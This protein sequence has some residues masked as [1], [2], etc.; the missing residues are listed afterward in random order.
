MCIKCSVQPA[1]NNILLILIL[2]LHSLL[3]QI[4]NQCQ[5]T[6]DGIFLHL[7]TSTLRAPALAWSHHQ[8]TSFRTWAGTLSWYYCVT[9]NIFVCIK[10]TIFCVI[11][12]ASFTESLLF[13]MTLS[14]VSFNTIC[15][16]SVLSVYTHTPSII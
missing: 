14:K 3:S 9:T 12:G 15:N 4:I 5:T 16:D 8:H 6:P 13:F 10:V 7:K 11:V 1:H 2:W